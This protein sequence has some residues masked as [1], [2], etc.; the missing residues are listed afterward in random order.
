M[1]CYVIAEI[2]IQDAGEYRRYLDGTDAI[3]EKF[4]AQVLAVDDSPLLLEGKMGFRRCV[5]IRFSSE[6]DANGWYHSAEY[7][8]IA[9][10]RR[11]ASKADLYLVHGRD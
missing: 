7:Q 8:A 6:V 4:N 11:R 5:L 3:L 9:P 10:H 1:N 2:T